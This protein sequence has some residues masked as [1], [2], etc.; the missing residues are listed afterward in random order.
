MSQ[1][2]YS[3]N[4]A[5]RALR[6]GSFGTIGLLA[7][8]FDRTGDAL[9]T[10]A[11]VS[12]AAKH[13]YSVTLLGVATLQSDGWTSAAARLSDQAVDG[14]VVIRAETEVPERLALPVAMPVAVSDSRLAG[15]YPTVMTDQ[16]QGTQDAI[17]HLLGLGHHNVHHL[18][19]PANSDPAALRTAAWERC[20]EQ[21]GIKPPPLLRGDWSAGSGYDAGRALAADPAVTAVFCANDEMAFGL[22]RALHEAGRRVPQDVSVVGFD[23]IALGE[24]ALPPLT[25]VSQDYSVI[26]NALVECL[27]GQI[28]EKRRGPHSRTLVH[29][30]LLIRAT[31]AP[32]PA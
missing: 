17:G 2:G 25:T 21:A 16:T 11:V 5:A 14:L 10:Q 19:G 12:A 15:F 32:P 24:F 1:L 9:T 20:L 31:T 13:G 23:G 26:G 4:V 6:S 30:Q 3:P 18:A 28:K 7:Y 22:L 29:P 8:R 27:L